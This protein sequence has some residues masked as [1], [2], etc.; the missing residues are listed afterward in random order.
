MVRAGLT[1]NSV[2]HTRLCVFE[3]R[4]GILFFLMLFFVFVDFDFGYMFVYELVFCLFIC[5]YLAMLSVFTLVLTSELNGVPVCAMCMCTGTNLTTRRHWLNRLLLYNPI[6]LF[7]L[8]N[9]IK[10]CFTMTQWN[11]FYYIT[12]L[13]RFY[14]ITCLNRFSVYNPIK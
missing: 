14:Y 10:S 4:V 13:N 11:R 7:L 12:Q 6:K 8:Y 2:A 3:P 1:T 9:P 5:F